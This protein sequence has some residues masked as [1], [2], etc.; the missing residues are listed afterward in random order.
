MQNLKF[1]SA[2]Q[3]VLLSLS[4][5]HR[6]ATGPCLASGKQDQPGHHHKHRSDQH[7]V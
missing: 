5:R 7:R 4:S 3:V 6:W 1:I 2:G